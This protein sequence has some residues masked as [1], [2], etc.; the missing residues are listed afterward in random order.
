MKTERVTLLTTPKFKAFLGSEARR[1]GISVAEL[2]RNRFEPQPSAD[3]AA[4]ET[5]VAELAMRL[6]DAR[7][8][9]NEGLAELHA[10]LAEKNEASAAT[11]TAQRK[12]A[13]TRRARA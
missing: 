6:K 4:I 7:K 2:V 13:T 9:L 3:E 5:M 11:K 10:W 12:R 1:E 8:S